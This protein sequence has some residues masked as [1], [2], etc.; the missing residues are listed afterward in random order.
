LKP[1]KGV[2]ARPW[3]HVQTS[4]PR[5]KVVQ[6]FVF[7]ELRAL[8]EFANPE[9]YKSDGKPAV[10][11]LPALVGPSYGITAKAVF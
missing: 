9:K 1:G 3:T 7:K 2:P 6:E 4:S 11:V 10:R 5:H 8:D